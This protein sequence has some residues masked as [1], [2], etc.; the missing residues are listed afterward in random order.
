MGIKSRLE[1]AEH[2]LG[3]GGECEACEVRDRFTKRLAR[4]FEE[5]GVS[6]EDGGAPTIETRCDWCG[7]ARTA[8]LVG[9]TIEEAADF[10]RMDAMYWAGEMCLPEYAPLKAAVLGRLRRAAVERYGEE[11]AGEI[12]E[13]VAAYNAELDLIRR[14]PL[15]YLC[16]VENCE[17]EYPKTF[18]EWRRNAQ[19]NGYKV[20][21]A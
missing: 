11:H 13:R 15:P 3:I 7:A 2:Q 20:R 17:C 10:E 4:R 9:H 18:A 8:R 5:W 16:R 1:R 19:A 21:A 14:P 6:A 12:A